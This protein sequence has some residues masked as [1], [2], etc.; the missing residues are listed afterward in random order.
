MQ[1]AKSLEQSVRRQFS[2]LFGGDDLVPSAQFFETYNAV[3]DYSMRTAEP[4][5]KAETHKLQW[6][7]LT[8]SLGLLALILFKVGSIKIGDVSVTVNHDVLTWYGGFL[9]ALMLSFLLRARLDFSRAELARRKDADKISQ[10]GRLVDA[11]FLK[12]RIQH[13]FWIE[14]FNQIGERYDS[15]GRISGGQLAAELTH[16]D[17]PNY[18]LDLEKLKDFEEYSTQI[19]SH[20]AFVKAFIVDLDADLGRFENRLG[21]LDERTRRARRSGDADSLDV[22]A[23]GH[24]SASRALFDKYLKPWFDAKSTLSSELLDVVV[25]KRATREF[26]MQ[27][28]Q[29]SLLEKARK[30]RALYAFTEIALPVGL[31]LAALAYDAHTLLTH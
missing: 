24:F 30:I 27:E 11:A 23:L 5:F 28:A 4:A 14:L 31:A 8:S 20:G 9:V 16:T 1:D 13:Y 22:H 10:L 6:T 3:A 29:L 19:E 15:Y 18:D 25:D 2:L 7:L 21:E 17:I 12:R 26:H